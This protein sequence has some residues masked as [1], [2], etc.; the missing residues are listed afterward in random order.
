MIRIIGQVM[1]FAA[2]FLRTSALFAVPEFPPGFPRTHVLSATEKHKLIQ[3]LLAAQPQKLTHSRAGYEAICPVLYE[4]LRTG[5]GVWFI[6]ATFRTEDPE[7]PRFDKYNRCRDF[8][9]NLDADR[10]FSSV[11]ELG[12]RHLALFELP[13]LDPKS[14]DMEVLY[15]EGDPAQSWQV[16]TGGYCQVDLAQCRFNYC[17]AIDLRTVDAAPVS[18]YPLDLHG[19]IAYEGRYMVVDLADLRAGSRGKPEDL[20]VYGMQAWELEPQ[21]GVLSICK[22]RVPKPERLP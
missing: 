15:A 9:S 18:S 19:I 3:Q 8:N 12:D 11:L 4:S 6:D 13:A 2:V 7:D 20:P 10:Q 1:V 14:A 17:A 22:W 5:K 21:E 16:F